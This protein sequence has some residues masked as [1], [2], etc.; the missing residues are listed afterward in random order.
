MEADEAYIR[1]IGQD[2]TSRVAELAKEARSRLAHEGFREATAGGPRPDAVMY[3][4][5]AL[6]R[7]C[8]VLVELNID[9][10]QHVAPIAATDTSDRIVSTSQR[11]QLNDGNLSG[12]GW[13][14]VPGAF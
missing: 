5:G 1:V 14:C 4:L 13:C 12:F 9:D 2:A 6:E 3:L 11:G 7:F 8:H 10:K